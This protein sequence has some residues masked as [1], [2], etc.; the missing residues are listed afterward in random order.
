MNNVML[1]GRLV[2]DPEAKKLESGK[3]VTNITLAVN[4]SFKNVDGIYETDFID[5]VLWEGL[6]SNFCEYCHKGDVVGI[7][8]RLQTEIVENEDGSKIKYTKV[9]AEKVTFLSSKHSNDDEEKEEE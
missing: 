3:E 9:I 7:R 1:V 6:S 8:G 5:C 4:R 2:S